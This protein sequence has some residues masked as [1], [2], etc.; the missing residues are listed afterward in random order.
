MA[1]IKDSFGTEYYITDF[2]L[3]YDLEKPG[4]LKCTSIIP[5]G[6]ISDSFSVSVACGTIMV[7]TSNMCVWGKDLYVC[8]GSSGYPYS[9]KIYRCVDEQYWEVAYEGSGLCEVASCMV[10]SYGGA[11]LY[12]GSEYSGKVFYT[13]TGTSWSQIGNLSGGTKVKQLQGYNY[14]GTNYMLALVGKKLWRSV[15][16]SSTWTDITATK[17]YNSDLI[18]VA[19]FNSRLWIGTSREDMVCYSS[20]NGATW[21][22]AVIYGTCGSP[23]YLYPYGSYLYVVGSRGY[24]A[25]YDTATPPIGYPLGGG[26]WGTSVE[27]TSAAT[28]ESKPFFGIKNGK[29]IYS[30]DGTGNSGTWAVYADLPSLGYGVPLSMYVYTNLYVGTNNYQL[31]QHTPTTHIWSV[32]KTI[33]QKNIKGMLLGGT[34]YFAV[35]DDAVDTGSIQAAYSGV[36]GTWNYVYGLPEYYINDVAVFGSYIYACTGGKGF[37]LRSADGKDWNI[38]YDSSSVNLYALGVTNGYIWAGGDA[39][40]YSYRSSDGLNWSTLPSGATVTIYCMTKDSS[41]SLVYCGCADGTI[42]TC[43]AASTWTIVASGIGAAVRCITTTTKSNVIV[44]AGTA[45]GRFYYYISGG[46][47]NYNTPYSAS[48]TIYGVT[49]YNGKFYVVH[50]DGKVYNST[51]AWTTFTWVYEFT[52][53]DTQ[54]RCALPYGIDLYVGGYSSDSKANIFKYVNSLLTKEVDHGIEGLGSIDCMHIWNNYIY[55]GGYIDAGATRYALIIRS[56]DGVRWE[57]IYRNTSNSEICA[58]YS[59]GSYLYAGE[60]ST[61]SA[62]VYRSYT[63]KDWT[64]AWTSTEDNI[65]DLHVFGSYIYAATSRASNY[66]RIYRSSDGTTWTEVW[67]SADTTKNSVYKLHAWGSYI[68]AGG[69]GTSSSKRFLIRSSTGGSGTWA[70]VSSGI[71]TGYT[72]ITAIQ[73][74]GSYIYVGCYWTADGR[75]VWR[76][77]SG[78]GGTWSQVTGLT[79]AYPNASCSDITATSTKIYA[80]V[81]DSEVFESSDGSTW[82]KIHSMSTNSSVK[83]IRILYDNVIT[84]GQRIFYQPISRMGRMI[85]KIKNADYFDFYSCGN[86]LTEKYILKEIEIQNESLMNLTLQ[87]HAIDLW[88]SFGYY[89]EGTSG[90]VDYSEDGI[91]A[92]EFANKIIDSSCNSKFRIKYCPHVKI[93]IKGEWL[94]KTQWMYEIAR[95][96]SFAINSNSSYPTCQLMS[97]SSQSDSIIDKMNVVIESNGDIF[98]M[99]AGTTIYGTNP[100]YVGYFTKRMTDIT[101]YVWDATKVNA[102]AIDYTNAIVLDGSGTGKSRKNFLANPIL[103]SYTNNLDSIDKIKE[104]SNIIY[105]P[106]YQGAAYVAVGLLTSGS[107]MSMWG[108]ITNTNFRV[109]CDVSAYHPSLVVAIDQDV[110]MK[111]AVSNTATLDSQTDVAF[112]KEA[113]FSFGGG[114]DAGNVLK[115]YR[116]VI[117]EER[118]TSYAYYVKLYYGMTELAS[119]TL[120]AG[121][122]ISTLSDINYLA[123]KWYKSGGVPTIKVYMSNVSMPDP[124]TA[125]PKIT[126][127]SSTAPYD[128][129]IVGLHGRTGFRLLGGGTA[130]YDKSTPIL[131]GVF[132]T[133]SVTGKSLSLW[134]STSITKPV[135]LFRDKSITSKDEARNVAINAYQ[136][137]SVTKELTIRV[138]PSRHMWGTTANRIHIGQWVTISGK[139]YY[140]GEYRVKSIK[141]TQDSMYLGLNN[142]KIN[143]TDYIDSIRQQVNK[144]DSFG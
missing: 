14:G 118:T 66:G 124:A 97:S 134:S 34:S 105:T 35:G 37:I 20:D 17:F 108:Q 69:G 82:T 93:K 11:Y 31:L 52:I 77:S 133:F 10:L 144:I 29:I 51:T 70:D 76:S 5:S 125:T 2:E 67:N 43:D 7:Q 48:R 90:F 16:G 115:M 40:G 110:V 86:S 98:I 139:G 130:T 107:S 119:A 62:K 143:F 38:V 3:N 102:N 28:F 96:L 92:D 30:T 8:T 73:S 22:W 137:A 95:N 87:S 71:G 74:F 72:G 85:Q 33:S 101:G 68:Y 45:N 24:I 55:A 58:L 46:S 41:Y 89:I 142:S 141:V 23:T 15:A 116:A 120:T 57:E 61:T 18:S 53:T 91:Y 12:F 136:N 65:E 126:Y 114:N 39:S 113:G 121:V 47:W 44:A 111:A 32:T 123:V 129:G 50:D 135:I 81:L 94:S 21:D 132:N 131:K 49:F 75:P 59:F 128:F 4:L 112:F 79:V 36:G 78:S 106:P 26:T 88:R 103:V 117:K 25:R 1:Q 99:P 19:S 6:D 56:P 83:S 80:I 54:A 27:G 127:S 9:G 100:N 122:D 84:A 140:D 138:D 104:L 64:L 13:S 63:G 60:K 109:D 42:R